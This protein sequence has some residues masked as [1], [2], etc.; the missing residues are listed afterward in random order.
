MDGHTIPTKNL[1][2]INLARAHEIMMISVPAHT[3]YRLQSCDVPFFKPLSSYYNQAANTRKW[4]RKNPSQNITQFQ[5][6]TF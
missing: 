5:A 1:E 3:T 6:Q 2:A 4:L